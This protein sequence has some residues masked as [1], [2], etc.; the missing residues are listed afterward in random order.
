MGYAR[1]GCSGPG[2]VEF[3]GGQGLDENMMSTCVAPDDY[4][5][6]FRA[7]QSKIN[8]IVERWRE[9]PD[10]E[11]IQDWRETFIP[12]VASFERA[13]TDRSGNVVYPSGGTL[14]FHLEGGTINLFGVD[15]NGNGK[16]DD[17]EGLRGS[18]INAFK[19]YYQQLVNAVH[20]CGAV[21][22][23]IDASLES[24]A[25]AWTNARLMATETVNRIAGVCENLAD[26][27]HGMSIS[28]GD[29]LNGTS[30]VLGLVSLGLATLGSGGTGTAAASFVLSV[31]SDKFP[32]KESFNPFDYVDPPRPSIPS[33]SGAVDVLS[34]L[35]NNSEGSVQ[36]A[37]NNVEQN[38]WDTV[39]TTILDITSN[40]RSLYNPRPEP[41]TE[42]PDTL[43]HDRDIAIAVVDHTAMISG[44]LLT[45][46]GQVESCRAAGTDAIMRRD[47]RL[48]IGDTG[49]YPRLDTLLFEL[50]LVLRELGQ[51]AYA[52]SV[53]LHAVVEALDQA[54]ADRQSL[55]QSTA[56]SFELSD[57]GYVDYYYHEGIKPQLPMPVI[58]N[59]DEL[60]S[61]KPW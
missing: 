37:L 51:E 43:R 60:M 14:W 19:Q 27:G 36:N 32:E 23:L 8:D 56:R 44:T 28:V 47:G 59:L 10:P 15:L 3:T 30:Q 52:A 40:R 5:A 42:V 41:V 6:D 48:G 29:L 45:A 13:S 12:V 58:P 4:V 24:E 17:D 34:L 7:I 9:L 31:V 16:S 18:A 61:G 49:P 46:T 54:E 33:Y 25:A 35:M 38:I 20:A 2:L 57:S 50:G 22:G 55:I 26:K 39:G 11:K 1:P 21:V 53:N